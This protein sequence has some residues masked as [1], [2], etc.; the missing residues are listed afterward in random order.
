MSETRSFK[1]HHQL[2]RSVIQRQA[3]TLSK[4]IL[5]GVMNAVDA[6][7]SKIDIVLKRNEVRISDDG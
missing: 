2:L 3:G 1:M 4:A 5:E 7:A 6:E